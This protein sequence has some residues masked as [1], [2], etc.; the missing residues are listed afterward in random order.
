MFSLGL[1]LV[2]LGTDVSKLVVLFKKNN[3]HMSLARDL[4][5][6]VNAYTYLL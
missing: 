6:G 1:H 2:C 5:N 4:L 3:L